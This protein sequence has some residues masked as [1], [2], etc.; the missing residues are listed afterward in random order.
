MF[1]ELR[2]AHSEEIMG[3]RREEEMEM[4]DDDLDENPCKRIRMEENG[5]CDQ[6]QASLREEND[7]LRWQLDSYRSE[8]ELLRKEQSRPGRPDDDAHTQTHKHTP[9]P[10]AQIQLLQQSMLNM[11]QQLLSLQE[12]LT[13]KEAELE[14]AREE[15]RYLEGEVLTLRDKVRNPIPPGVS[16]SNGSPDHPGSDDTAAAAGESVLVTAVRCWSVI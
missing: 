1:Q 15:H 7:S 10:E 8:V 9:S 6:T 14:Q 13:S 2:N 5:V 11:Q 4:S 16:H 3:I 12:K